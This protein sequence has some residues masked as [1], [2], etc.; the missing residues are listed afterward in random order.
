MSSAPPVKYAR[1]HVRP[2]PSCRKSRWCAESNVGMWTSTS[3]S[4]S[5]LRQPPVAS[6]SLSAPG[7]GPPCGPSCC[8]PWLEGSAR[9]ESDAC[10]AHRRRFTPLRGL[11]G[12]NRRLHRRDGELRSDRSLYLQPFSQSASCRFRMEARSHGWGLRTRRDYSRRG[13]TGHWPSARPLPAPPHHSPGHLRLR[14]RA[15]VSQPVDCAHLAVLSHLFH[16]WARGQRN[17]TVRLHPRVAHMVLKAS[18][19]GAGTAADRQRNWFYRDS[20]AGGV[21]DSASRMAQRLAHAGWH[22]A[23]RSEE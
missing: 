8:T 15:G 20:S 9:N 14:P 17:G 23:A 21:G 1:M 12:S 13:L 5:L 16:S 4:P 18:R 7:R 6:A 19:A 11:G 10:A 2:E 22:C 3:A